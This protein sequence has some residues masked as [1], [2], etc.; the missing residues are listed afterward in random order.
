MNILITGSQGFLAR[1]LS[2][3]LKRNNFKIYGIGR[4]AWKKNT[5]DLDHNKGFNKHTKIKYNI[6]ET[7]K[8]CKFI[9]N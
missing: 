8:I 7:P 6:K 1:N 9:S 2:K 5:T 3:K 4:G